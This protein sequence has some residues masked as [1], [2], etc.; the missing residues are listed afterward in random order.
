MQTADDG[1]T[2]VAAPTLDTLIAKCEANPQHI[3]GGVCEYKLG[4]GQPLSMVRCTMC[5]RLAPLMDLITSWTQRVDS[6]RLNGRSIEIISAGT[7]NIRDAEASWKLYCACDTAQRQARQSLIRRCYASFTCSGSHFVLRD[8]NYSPTSTSLPP[9]NTMMAQIVELF[10]DPAS[11]PTG[12]IHG[13]PTVSSI[14]FLGRLPVPL[15][16]KMGDTHYFSKHLLQIDY[17]G[18]DSATLSA[19]AASQVSKPRSVVVDEPLGVIVI[20]EKLG[21]I[22]IRKEASFASFL[23]EYPRHASVIALQLLLRGLLSL[24]PDSQTREY[25]DL[26]LIPISATTLHD[27][28]L[29]IRGKT[30]FLDIV[31]PLQKRLRL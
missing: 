5:V 12:F 11:L 21:Q 30:F 27:A 8:V 14:T 15:R 4:R 3:D 10:T 18:N 31:S 13:N 2:F 23:R 22:T 1:E 24:Y 26:S 17:G 20:D 19:A 7:K 6:G 9:L 16:H 28:F 25:R 29:E